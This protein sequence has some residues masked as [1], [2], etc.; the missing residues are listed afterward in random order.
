MRE[1]EKNIKNERE[2]IR[3][4][5]SRIRERRENRECKRG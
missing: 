5:T 4:K 2:G 3:R 1:L